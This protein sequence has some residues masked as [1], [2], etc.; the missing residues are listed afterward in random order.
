ML[1]MFENFELGAFQIYLTKRG[2]HEASTG[3]V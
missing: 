2:F 3:I 1:S